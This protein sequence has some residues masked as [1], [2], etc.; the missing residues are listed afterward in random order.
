[1]EFYAAPLA[2]TA[3][4][5]VAGLFQ[6][7]KARQ[8]AAL[9]RARHV[10]AERIIALLSGK[11]P[12]VWDQDELRSRIQATARDFWA[13]PTLAELAALETWVAQPLLDELKARW[14]KGAARRLA[15]VQFR[16]PVAFMQVHEGGPGPDRLIARLV[17]L[18]ETTWLDEADRRVRHERKAPFATYHSWI[19]I[20]G[21]GWR[22]EDVASQLSADE[23]PPSSVSC[24]I[25]PQAS[26]EELER[27]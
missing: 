20:D 7:R 14:P 21:Q 17:G 8:Q 13:L 23:P 11:Q 18:R 2:I 16:V 9:E 1:M 25:L 10:E 22:L 24:R 5:F 4:A 12:G 26:P 3:A 19:H 6:R 27:Y 15:T